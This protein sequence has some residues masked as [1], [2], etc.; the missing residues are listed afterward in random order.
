MRQISFR[1]S[2]AVFFLSSLILG[3]GSTAHARSRAARDP[4]EH[5]GNVNFP[6]SCSPQVQAAL[7]K[8]LALLHSFQYQESA[9]AFGNA[10]QRDGQ[11][12]MA[13]WGEAMALY[14]QLWDFPKAATL[15]E[16]RKDVEL[17]QKPSAQTPR[18]HEYVAPPL[19]FIRTIRS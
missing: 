12:A 19:R 17:A 3:V 4:E 16:G 14:H 15:A 7:E 9:Q 6:T 11:C 1:S 18:E 2:I 10:A 5:V 8:G 13:Y